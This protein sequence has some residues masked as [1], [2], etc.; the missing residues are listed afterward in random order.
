MPARTVIFDDDCGFC[1]RSIRLGRRLDWLGRIEW[2]PRHDP[3]LEQRF[4]QL[5]GEETQQ[6]MVSICPGGKALGGF[7]AVRDILRQFPLTWAPALLL[8]LPGMGWI[9]EPVYRW[10]AAHRHRFGGDASCPLPPRKKQ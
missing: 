2:T 8:Y 3:D 4:P 7:Y 9:G 6:R 5:S 10:I 1:Q